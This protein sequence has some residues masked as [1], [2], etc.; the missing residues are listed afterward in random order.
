VFLEKH[1]QGILGVKSKD[2]LSSLLHPTFLPAI[3]SCFILNYMDK[4][5]TQCIKHYLLVVGHYYFCS[6]HF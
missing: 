5:D 2:A 4:Y 3:I 6:H 1:S